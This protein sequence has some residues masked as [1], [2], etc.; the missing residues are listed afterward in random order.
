MTTVQ[1]ANVHNV[2]VDGTFDDCQDLVKAMFADVAFR[3]RGSPLGGQTPY[4]W[5][6]VMAQVV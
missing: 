4:N 2:A 6:R 1:S 5:A 3:V